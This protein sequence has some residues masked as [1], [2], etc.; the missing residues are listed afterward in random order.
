[1]ASG[2][3][4]PP[5]RSYPETNPMGSNTLAGLCETAVD[6]VDWLG[7]GLLDWVWLRG[8]CRLQLMVSDCPCV[9]L[10]QDAVLLGHF[11]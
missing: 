9:S 4:T 7:H 10:V 8:I 6:C 5:H 11:V 2:G 1:M 3:D